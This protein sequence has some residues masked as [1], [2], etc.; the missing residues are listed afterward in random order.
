[1]H[2]SRRALESAFAEF[3]VPLEADQTEAAFAVYRALYLSQDHVTNPGLGCPVAA[4]GTEVARGS[5]NLKRAFGNG[6][7]RV[8]DAIS[9]GKR[10]SVAARRT[11]AM[12]EFSMLVG[13]MVI[14][15]ASDPELA[16]EI[17]TACGRETKNVH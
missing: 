5:A 8:V 17:L 2:W 7:R 11:A 12:R 15:R 6:V 13:A 16:A 9:G 1:M 14:A 4:L 3:V 10:G